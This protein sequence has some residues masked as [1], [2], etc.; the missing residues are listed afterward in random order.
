MKPSPSLGMC[1]IYRTRFFVNR[2][3]QLSSVII[4]QKIRDAIEGGIGEEIEIKVEQN[5]E[6]K[7]YLFFLLYL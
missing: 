5:P 4:I 6:T 3:C 7:E 1:C 2:D